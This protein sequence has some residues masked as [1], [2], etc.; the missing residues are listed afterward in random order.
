MD[1]NMLFKG[2]HGNDPKDGVY[3]GDEGSLFF[4]RD[5]QAATYVQY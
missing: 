5:Y 1:H 3:P 4:C 2:H